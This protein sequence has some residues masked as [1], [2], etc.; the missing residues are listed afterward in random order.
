MARPEF[1]RLFVAAFTGLWACAALALPVPTIEINDGA[2]DNVLDLCTA[3]AGCNGHQTLAGSYDMSWSFVVDPDP[4]ITGTFNL[5]N[6]SNK[7]Q[8]FTLTV[9]LPIAPI[10]PSLSI[11]GSVATLGSLTDNNGNGA[12]LESTPF[13]DPIYSA[14]IDNV[15]VHTLL[16]AAQSFTAGSNSNGGTSTVTFGPASFSD[17]LAQ[18]ATSSISI[19]DAFNLTAGDAVTLPVFFDVQPAGAVPEPGSLALLGLA[20]AGLG[21]A[22]RRELN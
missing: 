1:A 17:I 22:R 11:A 19:R 14:R 16:D 12:T 10:G 9:T 20:L 15:S 13:N 8:T 3:A 18:S 7:T 2:N 5:T 21:F 4:S 6:L